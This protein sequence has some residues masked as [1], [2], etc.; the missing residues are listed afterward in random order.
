MEKLYKRFEV[1]VI[2]L[3][4]RMRTEK[5]LVAR[6]KL[7]FFYSLTS[8]IILVGSSLIL[9]HTLLSN[10]SESILESVDDPDT[11]LTI[12]NSTQGILQNRFI[13]VDSIILFFVIIIG[14]FITQ[15]TL[16]PIKDSMEKQ[17]RFVADASHELRTPVTII[18]SGIEV[19]L[20]NKNLDFLTARKTLE[21]T[22]VEMNELSQLSR[23]LLDISKYHKSKKVDYVPIAIDEVIQSVAIKIN[24]LALE[25]GITINSALQFHEF[26]LGST[27]E[28]ERVF[29]NILTN[30]ITHTEKGG[31]IHI[32]DSVS[33]NTYIITITDTGSGIEKDILRKI[34][35]P[36]FRGD[37]SRSSH[38]AGLGLTITQ[39]II[40]SHNGTINVKS[41]KN[42]GTNFTVTLPITSR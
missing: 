6:I 15:K 40:E 22:L 13:T 31:M 34:F 3:K 37:T 38:G 14:F 23:T 2:K 30:A 5:F 7:T 11:A 42:I 35:D 18:I 28:L 1:L 29:Y 10:L 21:N 17:K 16:K 4:L 25:K 9:Y 12:L 33:L 8:M 36:F 24:I 19:A 39:K 20:R 26:V 27:S 32:A 41:E